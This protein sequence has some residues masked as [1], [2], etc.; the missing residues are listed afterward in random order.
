MTIMVIS[1]CLLEGLK[2]M[3]VVMDNPLYNINCASFIYHSFDMKD[4]FN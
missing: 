3:L 1:L 2:C 4:G